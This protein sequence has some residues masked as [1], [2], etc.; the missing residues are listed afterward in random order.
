MAGLCFVL[1]VRDFRDECVLLRDNLSFS[2]EELTFLLLLEGRDLDRDS[3]GGG[4][5]VVLRLSPLLAVPVIV[6]VLVA[7][8]GA[9]SV[10]VWHSSASW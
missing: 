2:R 8:V 1:V 4:D 5:S 6:V 7:V 3:A 9:V 10:T